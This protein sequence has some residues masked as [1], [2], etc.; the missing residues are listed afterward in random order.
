MSKNY[1]LKSGKYLKIHI[2]EEGYDY[3]LYDENKRLIDGGILE[4]L[5]YT[6]DEAFKEILQIFNIP[7]NI[8]FQE[9]DEEIEE[10]FN[11]VFKDEKSIMPMNQQEL[12]NEMWYGDKEKIEK[13]GYDM[14]RI[15]GDLCDCFGN[16]RFILE[17]ETP[18]DKKMGQKRY[19]KCKVCGKYSHL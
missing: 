10:S 13:F 4:N 15:S 5:E 3:S 8:E 18:E 9:L 14:S 6:E 19:M 17:R 7:E 12:A 16:G 1:K 11:L 2:R